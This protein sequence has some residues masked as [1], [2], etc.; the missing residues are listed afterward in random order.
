MVWGVYE[1][2]WHGAEPFPVFRTCY[3]GRSYYFLNYADAAKSGGR[4]VGLTWTDYAAETGRPVDCAVCGGRLVGSE[5]LW[6]SCG[7][8]GGRS[9]RPDGGLPDGTPSTGGARIG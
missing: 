1:D 8:C 4:V 3:G 6:G 7:H 5:L 2:V 9:R